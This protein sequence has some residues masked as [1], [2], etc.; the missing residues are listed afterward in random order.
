MASVTSSSNFTLLFPRN[1]P[2]LAVA[3]QF[4]LAVRLSS[5]LVDGYGC[6]IHFSGSLKATFLTTQTSRPWVMRQQKLGRALS[7][8]LRLDSC[9]PPRR[10]RTIHAKRSGKGKFL[11]KLRGKATSLRN[12]DGCPGTNEGTQCGG[13][14]SLDTRLPQYYA[15]A[16]IY[17]LVSESMRPTWFGKSTLT[18]HEEFAPGSGAPLPGASELRTE[19][20]FLPGWNR[21]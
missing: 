6:V 10:A 8:K 15:T 2:G 14:E 18:S 4:I 13:Q 16:L 20:S 12:N 9:A 11:T 7:A 19:T 5:E 3:F 1:R 21:V 17:R